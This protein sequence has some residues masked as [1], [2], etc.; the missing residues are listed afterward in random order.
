MPDAC[1]A[2]AAGSGTGGRVEAVP[3]PLRAPSFDQ[4]WARTVDLAGP[5]SLILRQQPPEALE[6][7]RERARAAAAPYATA[8]GLAIPGLTLLASGRASAP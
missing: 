7:M 3:V 4:W 2:R 8:D 6:A 5:V 1:A